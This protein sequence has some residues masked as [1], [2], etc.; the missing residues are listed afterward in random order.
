MTEDFAYGV[1][2]SNRPGVP[3]VLI[4]AFPLDLTVFDPL[5]EEFSA[6]RRRLIRPDLRGFGGSP[7]PGDEEPS[8]DVYADDV[9]ALLDRLEVERAVVGGLSLGGYVTMAML[10]RHPDRVA[11]VILMDTKASEDT[12]EAKANRLRIATAV[13]EHG[14]RALRPMLGT[15]LGETTR[16]TR[17]DVVAQVTAWLDAARPAGVAWAQRAM[18]ARPPSFGTLRDAA[19]RGLSPATVVVGAEDTLT[20]RADA[21]AMAEALGGVPVHVVDGAGH[22]SPLEH[23]DAVADILRTDS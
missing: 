5:I 11:G 14:T 22:L 23:P 20:G 21:D 12:D 13:E 17:P 19:A 16:R 9:A 15:L 1:N 18:A 3:V 10:G 2:G 7:D 6:Q 4:H 8:V